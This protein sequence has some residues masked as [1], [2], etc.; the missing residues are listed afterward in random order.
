[1]GSILNFVFEG[2]DTL[3][4]KE[5]NTSLATRYLKSA[6]HGVLSKNKFNYTTT[7]NFTTRP[8]SKNIYL[9][10]CNNNILFLDEVN[11]KT[12]FDTFPPSFLEKI[13]KNEVH[14][15]LACIG[16]AT[17]YGTGYFWR[18]KEYL[19]LYGLT[20]NNITLVDG[21]CNITNFQNEFKKY[22]SLH[23]LVTDHRIGSGENDL[24]Y[25]SELPTDEEAYNT[26]KR[27]KHFLSLNR[28]LRPHR[29]YF[30]SFIYENNLFD[31]FYLSLLAKTSLEHY[32]DA[33]SQY[34]KYKNDINNLIPL[35]LDTTN[36][37]WPKEGF[38]TGDTYYKNN[39]L[40]SYFNITTETFFFEKATFFTEKTL[41]P[42][43][44]LQPFITI[45]TPYF[46]K[47]L[48]EMGFKTFDL[49]WD[50]SYD[51]IEDNQIRL[52]KIFDLILQISSWDLET[53]EKK[54]KSVLDICI[55][56]RNHLRNNI[57]ND[58]ELENILKKIENEW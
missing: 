48:K 7:F 54:Y 1:M 38:F 32:H 31:K 56:N 57:Y 39:Y 55:Y 28:V 34:K 30:A 10:E 24:K 40:D 9:L 11:G 21:N 27:S 35:E 3:N 14:I 58:N 37:P 17:E 12:I 43:E 18:L 13:R 2:T 16:E 36:I 33:F 44:G 4:G 42:I 46:L 49:I 29:T 20:E 25:I 19:R 8:N 52:Q 41:K 22:Y 23:F 51:D 26:T 5:F 6:Y 47:K 50:E 45:S 15:L 53:C